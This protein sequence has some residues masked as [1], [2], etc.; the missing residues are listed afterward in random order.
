MKEQYRDVWMSYETLNYQVHFH[1]I[2]TIIIKYKLIPVIK[3]YKLSKYDN[4]PWQIHRQFLLTTWEFT[5]TRSSVDSLTY[6][7]KFMNR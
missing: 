1:L 4:G 7:N 5:D 2:D 6:A 3:F